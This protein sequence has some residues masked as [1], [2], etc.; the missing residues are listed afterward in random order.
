MK[1]RNELKE[2]PRSVG[3]PNSARILRKPRRP[4]LQEQIR[5]ML[6]YEQADTGFDED[7]VSDEVIETDTR[8]PHE[9]VVD[10]ETGIEM[11]RYEKELL[12]AR[13]PQM[14]KDATEKAFRMHRAKKSKKIVRKPPL[15]EDS[16]STEQSD[17]SADADE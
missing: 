5:S 4:S 6:R 2:A 7:F 16:D 17:T 8:S 14:E 12:D 9:L 10:Q 11:C 13:R 15:I 3:G 1:K